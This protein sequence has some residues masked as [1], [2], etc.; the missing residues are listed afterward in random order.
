[1]STVWFIL[2]AHLCFTHVLYFVS[3]LCYMHCFKQLFIYFMSIH[4]YI[5]TRQIIMQE[6]CIHI[7]MFHDVVTFIWT[8][9]F[10]IR[11]VLH[12]IYL[13]ISYTIIL[14]LSYYRRINFKNNISH[15]ILSN[16]IHT[17][18][19]LLQV[20]YNNLLSFVMQSFT[21]TSH[22]VCLYHLNSTCTII[23][24]MILPWNTCHI[25]NIWVQWDLQNNIFLY[26]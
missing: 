5:S 18:F 9:W 12:I 21:Q 15:Y 6:I 13:Y 26:R 8:F 3:N 7:N 4:A 2:S 25:C 10:L 23:L 19:N 24:T 22:E 20:F 11:I 16:I 1:M 17:V 14:H